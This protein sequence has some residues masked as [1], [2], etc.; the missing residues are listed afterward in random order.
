[1]RGR[2]GSS[3]VVLSPGL[4]HTHTWPSRD[5]H[6]GLE[7]SDGHFGSRKKRTKLANFYQIHFLTSKY[8]KIFLRPGLWHGPHLGSSQRSPDLLQLNLAVN[9][10]H[11][12]EVVIRKVRGVKE[13]LQKGRRG[14]LAPKKWAEFALPE[15][16]LSHPQASLAGYLHGFL[17]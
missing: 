16:R 4:C 15:M 17:C 5:V 7:T 14:G 8:T 2:G 3:C 10:W 1:M 12:G 9:Y 6:F 11:K 13:R